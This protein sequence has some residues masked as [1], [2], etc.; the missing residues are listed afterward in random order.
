MVSIVISGV[1]APFSLRTSVGQMVRNPR[2]EDQGFIVSVSLT[3]TRMSRVVRQRIWVRRD[4]V[5]DAVEAFEGPRRTFYSFTFR[6]QR[7]GSWIPTVR[8]DNWEGQDHV[9]RYDETGILKERIPWRERPLADVLKLVKMFR[10]NLLT[11]DLAE[12]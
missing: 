6:T 2:N 12:L 9:D 10:R 4:E 5:L 3:P 1:R 7:D 8:W 11:M